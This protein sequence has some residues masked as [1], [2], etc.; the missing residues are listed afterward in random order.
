[1]IAAT[2]AEEIRSHLRERA[3]VVDEQIVQLLQA[4]VQDPWMHGA[5]A[6]HLGW[7]DADFAP[8]PGPARPSAGKRLRP[9]LC[10]L[11]FE[12][13]RHTAS[14]PTPPADRDA[15]LA[16]AV[17]VELVHNYSLIHDDIQD[18]DDR[19]RGRPALWTICGDAQAINVGD[20]LH[21]LAY[22]CLAQRTCQGA[23]PLAAKL[24]GALAEAGIDMSVGQSRDLRLEEDP[25]VT[26]EAYLQ[27]VA[28]K[29]AA[30]MRCATY[31]GALVALDGSSQDRL[32][33]FAE[34]GRQFGLVFQIRDDILGIWGDEARTGKS[35]T[36]DI[37][38]R[39]K[40]LPVVLALQAADAKTRT[41]LAGCYG[42]D[43]EQTTNEQ[44][45][46]IR[47]I[48]DQCG[49]D[50]LAQRHAEDHCR[51]ALTALAQAGGG[52]R[53]L[54]TNPSL[55]RLKRLTEFVT[56]RRQ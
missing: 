5:I 37:R 19:R 6:Y 18:R 34:F 14:G 33:A 41:T 32:E 52:L 56:H 13:A 22:R 16:F 26:L 23:A 21:D 15:A 54:G 36:N 43:P 25:Q 11:C 40:S 4:E 28:G 49:A 51:R 29:T 24:M 27:M 8:L 35:A 47:H 31:G 55:A 10:L 30:L 9:A 45:H 48:L 46:R 20:C 3:A 1:M 17:A 39:K 12:A 50:T 38:Q 7:A 2:A 53:A 42:A 44:H